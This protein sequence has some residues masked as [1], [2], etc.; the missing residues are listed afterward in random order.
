MR[1]PSADPSSARFVL[2][3]ALPVTVGAAAWVQP[4]AAWAVMFGWQVLLAL[5][6]RVPALA[7]SPPAAPQT[8]WHRACLRLHV[9]LQAALL[10]LGLVIAA[11][12][13][14]PAWM[15][16]LLALGVGG[17]TGSQGI[18]FAHELGH[19]RSRFDRALGW[20]L[21]ASVNYA[22]FM[23]EHYRGHHV[24]VATAA[25]PA[26]ARRGESLWR[27]LPRTLAGSWT[28][29][30]ALEARRLQQ[31][32]RGWGRSPLAWAT[33]VQVALLIGIAWALGPLALLFWVL[34]SA[35][36]VFL[37]EAI[38]YIEHYGL[39]RRVLPGGRVEPFGA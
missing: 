26:S 25:D 29:A 13:G 1:E 31:H 35:Y 14:H 16:A 4:W 20:G 19:S 10:A 30:W 36:A 34:Q 11:G 21:M 39:Q 8:A 2:A 5:A 3:W 7:H 17:V 6:E 28:S 27:F 22:H 38:N 33:A 15:V 24:R 12:G 18:T 9:P 37:L 32:R 23:V